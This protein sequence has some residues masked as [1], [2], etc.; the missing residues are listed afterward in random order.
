[1]RQG[2]NPQK[3]KN[4][5]NTSFFHRVII[6]VH[7]PDNKNPYYE[8][9]VEVLETVLT[10]LYETINP[11][12]TA[13]TLIDNNC[14]LEVK[15]I[16]QKHRSKIDKI[17]IYSENK[18]KVNALLAEARGCYESFVTLADADVLFLAGWEKA[19][20]EIFKTYKKAGVVAPLPSQGLALENNASLFF[21]NYL[22]GKVE[23]DKIVSDYD[24]NL[25]IEGLN[26]TALLKR[27]NRKFDWRQKQYYLNKEIRAIV[28]SGHFV[29]TYKTAIFKGE[30]SFP[31]LKFKNG[32]ED[33]F[34]DQLADKNGLYRLSTVKTF[35]YH[36]GTHL[37]RN[38]KNLIR[39]KGDKPSE[40]FLN[41][42]SS[43]LKSKIVPYALRKFSFK[44]LKKI[45]KL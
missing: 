24:C 1:M 20:F 19:I 25:Y 8:N 43:K 21:D 40:E 37:D 11:R 31:D 36:I 32:Y 41:N 34:I 35:A 10:Q 38:I 15:N 16:I 13:I 6:P 44:V 42:I 18:G 14:T 30:N 28:G 3:N 2:I 4:A 12:I 23:K 26:N 27:D 7:I 5:R 17:V 39:K 45:K 22:L 9:G 29:A 33:K